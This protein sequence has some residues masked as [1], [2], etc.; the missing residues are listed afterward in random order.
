[1]VLARSIVTA[2]VLAT[3]RG[4][5]V[6]LVVASHPS[7]LAL[8]PSC[9]K[10]NTWAPRC[11]HK[12][13]PRK[14]LK[15][16]AFR[17]C[18]PKFLTWLIHPPLFLENSALTKGLGLGF[19]SFFPTQNSRA[20]YSPTTVISALHLPAVFQYAQA[21]LLS[22]HLSLNH[23]L[24]RC[25]RP[26]TSHRLLHLPSY[27]PSSFSTTRLSSPDLSQTRWHQYGPFIY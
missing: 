4:P 5:I 9:P 12:Q 15:S 26:K 25:L 14:M 11:R 16:S 21:S 27:T 20:S 7:P 6:V 17:Y 22:I 2:A 1:M 18:L 3:P 8:S 19:S 23:Y 24:P 13:V 10:L